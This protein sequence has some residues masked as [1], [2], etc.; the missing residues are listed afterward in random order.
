MPINDFT[1]VSAS[2]RLA[3]TTRVNNTRTNLVEISETEEAQN[4]QNTDSSNTSDTSR[5][6]QSVDLAQRQTLESSTF[7]ASTSVDTP[8]ADLFALSEVNQI[9]ENFA[10]TETNITNNETFGLQGQIAIALDEE[11]AN[12]LAEQAEARANDITTEQVTQIA[13][14]TTNT[15]SEAPVVEVTAAENAVQ[16][17]NVAA[18]QAAGGGV[19]DEL[20]ES[21]Q[22]PVDR[23]V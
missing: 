18:D 9:A 17:V 13:E 15:E 16:A 19:V 7:L 23:F 21:V 6:V 10:S 2:S 8:A 5:P 12:V 11:P 1:S 22:A 14:E 4:S 3:E 20:T